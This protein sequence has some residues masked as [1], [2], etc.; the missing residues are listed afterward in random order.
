MAK[1]TFEI[2]TSDDGFHARFRAVNGE[3]VW[4]T[5]NYAAKASAV[6]AVE[7]LLNLTPAR[8]RIEGPV[9]VARGY[10]RSIMANFRE[11]DERE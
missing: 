10:G 3:I 8:C 1:P 6:H 2:V 11:V 4:S 7:I 9:I 5:E